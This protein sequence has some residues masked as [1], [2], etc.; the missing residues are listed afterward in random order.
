MR[1]A[2]IRKRW[3][4]GKPRAPTKPDVAF[5][6][7]SC[8]TSVSHP[9]YYAVIGPFRTKRAAVWA[10]VYGANNPHFQIVADAERLARLFH[11]ES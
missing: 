8:P 6:S 7:V 3:Y 9:D 1:A 5:N 2:R 11:K 4:V 10:S